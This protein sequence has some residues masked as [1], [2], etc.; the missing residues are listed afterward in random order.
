M[1]EPDSTL[2]FPERLWRD[3]RTVLMLGDV[4]VAWWYPSRNGF[5]GVLVARD[6]E[7]AR[8]AVEGWAGSA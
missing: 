4:P 8:A 6:E 1:S 5:P 2:P 3:H 7:Q